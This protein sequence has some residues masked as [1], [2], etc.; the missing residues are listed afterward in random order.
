MEGVSSQ[1]QMKSVV[2]RCVAVHDRKTKAGVNRVAV[3][4]YQFD[5]MTGTLT[6]GATVFKPDTPRQKFDFANHAVTAKKRF[7]EHP[8]VVTGVKDDKTLCDFNHYLRGLLFTHGCR[9]KPVTV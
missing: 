3:L 4:Y 9:A 6:Y 7:T 5:R 8:V 2:T 1:K